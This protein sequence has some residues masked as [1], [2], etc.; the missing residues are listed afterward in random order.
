MHTEEAIIIG[1]G[2]CG[3]AAAI[4]L[5]KIGFSP[6]VIEKRNIVHSIS[7]YPTYMQFFSSPEL[8]EI[9]EIP[10]TTPTKSLKA[11][12]AQLLPNGCPSPKL[13]MQPYESI[14]SKRRR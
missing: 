5:Q 12:G 10:F 7:Q 3:L 6:L 1:A 11:G 4:E 13:R 8:L 9:G 2:P 14:T